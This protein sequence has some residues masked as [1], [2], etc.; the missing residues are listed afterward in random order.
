MKLAARIRLMPPTGIAL[1]IVALA[2]NASMGGWLLALIPLN[3]VA[4]SV[5]A[6]AWWRLRKRHADHS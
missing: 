2:V 5:C 1:N 4:G 3:I 6:W